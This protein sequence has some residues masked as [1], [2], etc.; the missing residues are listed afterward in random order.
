MYKKWVYLATIITAI[1]IGTQVYSSEIANIETK[2]AESIESR[3]STSLFPEEEQ[4]EIIEESLELS[5]ETQDEFQSDEEDMYGFDQLSVDDAG[6]Y[7]GMAQAYKDGYV[8][9][10][11]NEKAV[12]II[13]FLAQSPD[14]YSIKVTP[15]MGNT[16]DS[17]F[18]IK[19]YQKTFQRSKEVDK[20]QNEEKDIFLVKFEFDLLPERLNGVYPINFKI[21][22]TYNNMQM[23]QDFAVYVYIEDSIIQAEESENMPVSTPIEDEIPTSEPKI[24]ITQCSEMPEKIESGDEFSFKVLLKNT[25]KQKYVQNMTVTI[26]SDNSFLTLLADSNVFYYEY[27]GTESTLEI[28]LQFKCG[29]EVPEGKYVINLDMSYDNPEAMSLTS[30]GKI[31]IAV[32]QKVN[33]ELEIGNFST[34]VNAG[35][36]V[37]IPIQVLNLGRGKLYNIRCFLDVPG[38]TVDK[39]LFLGDMEGGSAV[40]GELKAF[41]GMVNSSGK[42]DGERYGDTSGKIKLTYENENGQEYTASKDISIKVN[43][44]NVE[45]EPDTEADIDDNIKDQFILGIVLLAL[46]VIVGTIIP[47][48]IHRNQL[49]KR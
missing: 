16:Q 41:A 4:T 31:E 23:T 37:T 20:N 22:Y 2:S 30:T 35:D 48:V 21:D 3:Q 38:L 25:N 33:M 13:P 15:D 43:P 46:L 14:I 5:I 6:V 24:I 34:E 9:S 19:N 28:P 40:S 44:L 36:Y 29:E 45:Q 12:I 8:P 7:D 39:S 32:T 11:E 17:P 1:S 47:I 18:I 42:T 49:R 10:I 27:L 26:S